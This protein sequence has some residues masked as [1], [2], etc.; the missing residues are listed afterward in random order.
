MEVTFNNGLLDRSWRD[1]WLFDAVDGFFNEVGEGESRVL[2]TV[3]IVEDKD[4][5]RFTLDMP[6]LSADSLDVKI[7]DN[8]LTIAGERKAPEWPKDSHVHRGERRYGT[9]HRA[10][11][12]PED[13]RHDGIKA[14]Y[15]DGV[16][17]VT[18][19][20]TPEAKPVRIAV[21]YSKN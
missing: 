15:K 4:G 13:A 19:P 9:M 12:L 11:R 17:E 14:L 20:K 3:E 8:N 6:G 16:L 10:F 2:P 21:D 7:E 5:Y 1:G 18:V